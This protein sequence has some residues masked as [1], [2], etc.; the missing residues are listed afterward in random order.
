MRLRHLAA[1][2][3]YQCVAA[4]WNTQSMPAKLRLLLRKIVSQ[5]AL[6]DLFFTYARRPDNLFLL[7]LAPVHLIIGI[8]RR[9]EGRRFYEIF[10]QF[11]EESYFQAVIRLQR[12]CQFLPGALRP[13]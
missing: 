7:L 1:N 13:A 4:S 8:H 3:P 2:F 5:F 10:Q 9:T 12:H 11:E 6:A